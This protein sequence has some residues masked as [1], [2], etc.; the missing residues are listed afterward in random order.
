MTATSMGTRVMAANN[1]SEFEVSSTTC[2]PRSLRRAPAKS[3]VCIRVLSATTMLTKSEP[4]PSWDGIGPPHIQLYEPEGGLE[5]TP[6]VSTVAR[7]RGENYGKETDNISLP[8]DENVPLN[9]G[10]GT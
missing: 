4:N 3:W 1:S 8:T 6:F 7:G 2:R 10:T 9:Y 5:N